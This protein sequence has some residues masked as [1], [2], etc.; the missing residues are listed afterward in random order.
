[1]NDSSWL[2]KVL[3]DIGANDGYRKICY[4]KGITTEILNSLSGKF[5][6]YNVGSKIEGTVT[7]GVRSDTDG[8]LCDENY[9]V[10]EDITKADKNRICLLIVRDPESPA[11]YVKLQ[12]VVSEENE[13]IVWE[14]E[15]LFDC[16]RLCIK[17]MLNWIKRGYC[18]NYFIPTEN[19]FEG[20]MIE[21]LKV[22]SKNKLEKL[23]IDGFD[24]FLQVHSNNFCDYVRSRKHVKWYEKLLKKGIEI[25]E[26]DL[27]MKKIDTCHCVMACL[28]VILEHHK[29]YKKI[30]NFIEFLWHTL[31]TIEHVD[32]IYEHTPQDTRRA[33]SLL[34]P[35]IYTF[36]AS[37]ISAMC[38]QQPN[39]HVRDFL[40]YGCYTFFMKGDLHGRLKFISVLYAIGCYK[41]CKWYLDQENEKYI[42]YNPSACVCHNIPSKLYPF[43]TTKIEMSQL[44]MSTCVIFLPTE[45]PIT[46]DALKIEMFRYIGI[47]SHRSKMKEFRWLWHTWAVVDSNLYYFFLKFLINRKIK[48]VELPIDALLDI[49]QAVKLMYIS[50]IRH[51]DVFYNLMSWCFRDVGFTIIAL[52]MSRMSWH[53]QRPLDSMIS[54]FTKEMRQKHYLFNS[55]K[56][57]ALVILYNIWFTRKPSCFKFCFQCFNITHKAMQTCS[58]CKTATYCS[59]QCKNKNKS[60][61]KAV[62]EIVRRYGDV[63]ETILYERI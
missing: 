54:F 60:V 5:T 36:L 1:M 25:Y 38:I 53:I 35:Y 22:I 8:V 41:E 6:T 24:C 17:Q 62:C 18:P 51:Q 63:K 14:K 46:P 47:S 59:N 9:P 12:L 31:Y 20:K 10:I 45:L 7:P 33:L 11:G 50:N 23:L 56:I 2:F 44:K 55:A 58:R 39:P 30:T 40:L 27:Y 28:G 4:E 43:N 15:R 13:E 57:H 19:M 48:G 37:N 29:D 32:T 42:K 21:S 49:N 3:D 34:Q 16:V 61:H 26:K 52:D